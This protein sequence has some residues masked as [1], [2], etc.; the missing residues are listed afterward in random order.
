VSTPARAPKIEEAPLPVSDVQKRVQSLEDRDLQLWSIAIL[1]VVVLAAWLA[2]LLFPNII[3][4]N[5]IIRADARY[6]PQLLYGLITLIVLS[7]IYLLKQRFILRRTREELVHEIMY[8][9]AVEKLTL[10]DPLTGAYNRRYLDEII[11]K[12]I[13]RADRL[14]T[15]LTFVMIDVDDFKDVN[16]R[17]GHLMGD[18]LLSEVSNVLR[19]TFRGSDTIIRYGGDEFLVILESPKEKHAEVALERLLANVE[20]W[21]AANTTVDYEMGLSWGVSRYEKGSNIEEILDLA[22]RNM[23]SAKQKR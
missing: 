13:Q 9:R 3:W 18:R 11:T 8:S 19:H 21:N 4:N 20:A 5:R 7:N 22:D 14:G 10:T 12:D 23:F 17:F 2:M 1:V 16:T 6:L 15:Y